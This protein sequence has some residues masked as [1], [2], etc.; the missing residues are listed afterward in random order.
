[1]D[2][3]GF[4][5]TSREG[6]EDEDGLRCTISGSTNDTAE[7]PASQYSDDEIADVPSTPERVSPGATLDVP[8]V[9]IEAA[10]FPVA[11]TMDGAPLPANET[12][13]DP[14][15]TLNETPSGIDALKVDSSSEG[16]LNPRTPRSLHQIKSPPGL[17]M[18][19]KVRITEGIVIPMRSVY[20]DFKHDDNWECE[21]L[22]CLLFTK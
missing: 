5:A 1:M 18:E 3:N 20:Y 9:L 16:S 22:T 11:Q 17:D 8:A 12:E 14:I 2:Q 19:T 10:A 4:P 15:S 7:A 6:E 21:I 13:T